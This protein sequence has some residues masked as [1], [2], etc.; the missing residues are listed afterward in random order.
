MTREETKAYRKEYY[1]KHK[2]KALEYQKKYNAEHKAERQKY[3]QK[4]KEKI[5]SYN[6]KYYQKNKWLWEDVYNIKAIT[7]GN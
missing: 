2:Y 4:N 5:N 7:G 6:R 3:Y 1:K